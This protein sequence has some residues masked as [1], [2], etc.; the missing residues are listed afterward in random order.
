MWCFFA[1]RAIFESFPPLDF[2]RYQI[3]IP[4][5]RKGLPALPA[6]PPWVVLPVPPPAAL[7][8]AGRISAPATSAARTSAAGPISAGRWRRRGC[9]DARGRLPAGRRLILGAR[10]STPTAARAAVLP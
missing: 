1:L 2:F 6:L 8:P 4:F 9:V 3:H 5:P 7:P 10:I